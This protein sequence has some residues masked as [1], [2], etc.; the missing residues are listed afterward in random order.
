MSLE[1]FKQY[2]RQNHKNYPNEASFKPQL[3]SPDTIYYKDFHFLDEPLINRKYPPT[4]AST[5]KPGNQPTSSDTL[6]SELVNSTASGTGNEGI[7]Q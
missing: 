7:V 5:T 4:T 3:P 6:T 1:D 2:N